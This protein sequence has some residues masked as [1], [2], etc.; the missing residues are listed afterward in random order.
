MFWTKAKAKTKLH[1]MELTLYW[2]TQVG[3]LRCHYLSKNKA[4]FALRMKIHIFSTFINTQR[5][6]EWDEEMTVF[7]EIF[8][9]HEDILASATTMGIPLSAI[10]SSHF[11]CNVHSSATHIR[12]EHKK[13]SLE[14]WNITCFHRIWY[15]FHHFNCLQYINLKGSQLVTEYSYNQLFQILLLFLFSFRFFLW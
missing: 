1:S 11:F 13:N 4:F 12:C 3:G 8:H 7:Q 5:K 10:I 14:Q 2:T 9:L 15:A 6:T